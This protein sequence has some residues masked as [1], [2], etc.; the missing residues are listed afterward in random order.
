[1]GIPRG[2]QGD[3]R[4]GRAG[5]VVRAPVV[6]RIVEQHRGA[7]A[8]DHALVVIWAVDRAAGIAAVV[9]ATASVVAGLSKGRDRFHLHEAL[10]IGVVVAIVVHGAAFALDSYFA[11]GVARTLVPFASPYRALAVAA[12]QVAAYGLIALSLTFYLRRRW[13]TPRWRAAHRLI[14]LFWGLAVIH[15]LTAGSDAARPWFLLCVLVPTAV[16]LV[17]IAARHDARAASGSATAS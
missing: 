1:M 2:G 9:L 8:D 13:G 4:G 10:G 11:A 17:R 15:G 7:R 3:E 16:A 6:L 5:G 12:G 14:P